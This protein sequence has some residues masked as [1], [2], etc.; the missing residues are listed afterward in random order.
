MFGTI[1]VGVDGSGGGGRA[2]QAVAKIAADT[3]DQV[4]VC[5]GTAVA[6]RR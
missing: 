5:H 1:V 2:V 3:K 4:V 6:T